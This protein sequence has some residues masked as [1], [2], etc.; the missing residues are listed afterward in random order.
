MEAFR[1]RG[2]N[3]FI[4]SHDI[5]DFVNVV[6]GRSTIVEEVAAAPSD[7]RQYLAEATRNLLGKSSFLDVLPGFV[8]GDTASQQRVPLIERRLE[9]I[10]RLS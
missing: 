8:Y 7:L 6:D 5:E 9:A 1:G 10:S 4:G 2:E 3:D